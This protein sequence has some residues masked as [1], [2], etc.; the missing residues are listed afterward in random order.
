[1]TVLTP[2]KKNDLEKAAKRIA[3]LLLVFAM[4]E[5][6]LAKSFFT[7]HFKVAGGL[8]FVFAF[9]KTAVAI[10]FY[11]LARFVSNRVENFRLDLGNYVFAVVMFLISSIQIIVVISFALAGY[12]PAA[13]IFVTASAESTILGLVLFITSILAMKD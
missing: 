8:A 9:V 11:V 1:M 13:G 6:M 4:V 2:E 7:N 3:W 5:F 12:T 10:T